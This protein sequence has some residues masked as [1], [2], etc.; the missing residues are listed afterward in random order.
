MNYY[1]VCDINPY[2]NSISRNFSSVVEDAQ[3]WL[4]RKFLDQILPKALMQQYSGDAYHDHARFFPFEVMAEC[5][6]LSCVGGPCSSDDSKFVCGVSSLSRLDDCVIYSIG[7]NNEWQFE[8]DLLERTNCEVHTFDCTGKI[9]R[10]QVPRHDRM[11]FHHICVGARRAE[12]IGNDH[13][14]CGMTWKPGNLCGDTWTL[15]EIQREFGHDRVDLLKLDI[16]GWEWPLF[17]VPKTDASMPMQVLMEVHWN[18]A[19]RGCKHVIHDH[20]MESAADIARFM[21]NLLRLGYILVKRDDNPRC[22]HCSEI[23]LIRVAC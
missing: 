19:G 10:F 8:M 18:W 21:S 2:R 23:T 20:P 5:T 11:K 4:D 22:K 6:D 7:G 15:A 3:D 14:D 1:P 9:E 12:G 16:E 17:D 13:P